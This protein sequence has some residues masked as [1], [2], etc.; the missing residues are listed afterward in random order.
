M[1]GGGA[2]R[3][4]GG[5]RPHGARDHAGRDRDPHVRGSD[6]VGVVIPARLDVL[7]GAATSGLAFL[8]AALALGRA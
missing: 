5:E 3:A 4:H 2:P 1:S 8:F 7:L 6:A